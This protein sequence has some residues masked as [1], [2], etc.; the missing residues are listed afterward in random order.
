[1][2]V[3]VNDTNLF[4]GARKTSCLMVGHFGEGTKKWNFFKIN[5][6][7]DFER[8]RPSR[9]LEKWDNSYI[10]SWN[11]FSERDQGLALGEVVLNNDN[12]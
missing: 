3:F 6:N 11:Y 5:N 2:N 12:R 4:K 9:I 1:M 8:S 10:L 7:E